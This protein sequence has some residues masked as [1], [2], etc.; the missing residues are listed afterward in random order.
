VR[1]CGTINLTGGVSAGS[2][3][4][5]EGNKC[6][7]GKKKFAYATEISYKRVSDVEIMGFYRRDAIGGS[8]REYLVV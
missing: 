5:S 2:A 7:P 3:Q 8:G 1:K 6:L 4:A